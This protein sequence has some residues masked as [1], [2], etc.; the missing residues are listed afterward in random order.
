MIDS[1][2]QTSF[3]SRAKYS[4]R[5][6]LALTAFVAVLCVST[7]YLPT[8]AGFNRSISTIL[9]CAGALGAMLPSIIVAWI[10]YGIASARCWRLA[11]GTTLASAWVNMFVQYQLC[12]SGSKSPNWPNLAGALLIIIAPVLGFIAACI[13]LV[14]AWVAS[15]I[16]NAADGSRL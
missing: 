11:L 2:A 5:D 15:S 7:T 13:I 16:V 4:I 10:R 12:L 9:F 3:S 6:L 1:H 14:L 8:L